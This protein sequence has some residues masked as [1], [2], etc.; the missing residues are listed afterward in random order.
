MFDKTTDQDEA[1]IIAKVKNDNK[2]YVNKIDFNAV[3]DKKTNDIQITA[4]A[5]EK[6]G[7]EGST[8]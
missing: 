6:S 2:D 4:K 7:Y 1:S 8:T 5:K 3:I